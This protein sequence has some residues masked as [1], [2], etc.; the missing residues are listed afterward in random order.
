MLG[1]PGYEI[2]PFVC[3][4]NALAGSV[5]ARRLAFLAEELNYDRQRLQAWALAHAVLSACWTIE[6]R[7]APSGRGSP[8]R[9]CS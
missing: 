7:G 1:D 5:L 8:P 4:P 9:R 6:D 3:N 2:G